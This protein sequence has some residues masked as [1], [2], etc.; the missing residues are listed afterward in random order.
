MSWGLTN[1]TV[2][3]QGSRW[4]ALLNHSA[5]TSAMW[6]SRF[7]PWP[8]APSGDGYTPPAKPYSSSATLPVNG[9]Q[10]LSRWVRCHLPNQW[11][12]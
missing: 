1:E 11:V 8:G 7:Q 4:L 5:N 2:V 6:G 10:R 12:W 9:V 3:H